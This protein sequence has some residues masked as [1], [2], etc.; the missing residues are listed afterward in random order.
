MPKRTSLARPKRPFPTK[1]LVTLNP[2]VLSPLRRMTDH[3]VLQPSFC[4][5]PVV[6]ALRAGRP[7]LREGV[8]SVRS[9]PRKSRRFY[10]ACEGFLRFFRPGRLRS[11]RP[12]RGLRSLRRP[13]RKNLRKPSLRSEKPM[14]FRSA[15]LSPLT[16][17]LRPGP[18]SAP[19]QNDGLRPKRRFPAKMIGHPAPLRQNA[20]IP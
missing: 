17:S 13:G 5:P 15:T 20:G 4:P 11:L 1:K 8:S 7:G 3:F 19:G 2:G 18:P 16:P 6:L 12:L 10:S 14:D 9:A